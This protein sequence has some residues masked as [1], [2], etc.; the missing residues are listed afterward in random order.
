MRS[1]TTCILLAAAGAVS[2]QNPAVE[3]HVAAEHD[4]DAFADWVCV[5]ATARGALDDDAIEK[6]VHEPP[7]LLRV[8]RRPGAEQVAI[9]QFVGEVA[10]LAE[11]GE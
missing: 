10:A 5:A 9:G 6:T 4:L 11:V 7:L 1:M 3:E 8:Q 2:A